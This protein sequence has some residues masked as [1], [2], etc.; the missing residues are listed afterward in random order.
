MHRILL[1]HAAGGIGGG[2]ASLVDMLHMLAPQFDVSVVL[3][4]APP[5]AAMLVSASGFR[6]YRLTSV[7]C[8]MVQRGARDL[9]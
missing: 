4:K 8:H 7:S 6:W 3:P 1:I 9:E 2:T 5:E